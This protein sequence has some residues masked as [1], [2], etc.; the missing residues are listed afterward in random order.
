MNDCQ[1]CGQDFESNEELLEH[2]KIHPEYDQRNVLCAKCGKRYAL[3]CKLYSGLQE[4][5]FKPGFP[6]H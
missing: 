1:V 4:S 3:T 5:S 6:K 2:V